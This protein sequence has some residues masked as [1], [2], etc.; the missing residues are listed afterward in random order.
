MTVSLYTSAIK[1][2]QMKKRNSLFLK[3]PTTFDWIVANIPD[4]TSRLILVAQAFMDMSNT[5]E[6]PLSQK[7][8]NTALVDGKDARHRVTRDV[9]DHV[10]GYDVI[11]RPGKTSILR[12]RVMVDSSSAT[13]HPE[14][15][16]R[17]ACEAPPRFD[18]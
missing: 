3:G 16:S 1:N 10:K 9:R 12:R 2:N 7:I 13:S 8:W 18:D 5:N 17:C 14:S 15:S 4:P 6:I 11:S